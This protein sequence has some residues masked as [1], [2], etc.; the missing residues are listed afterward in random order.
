M[1]VT[2]RDFL[3]LT[4]SG[5]VVLGGLPVWRSARAAEPGAPLLVVVF[6]RGGADALSLVPPV[7]DP[8]YARRRGALAVEGALPFA[9]GFGLHP[10]LAP[11]APLVEDGRLAVV[12]CAGSH[13][14]SRSHFEAQ[15]RMELGS[16]DR[17]RWSEGGWLTRA[18]GEV[19]A[20]APFRQLGFGFASPAS[21][22]GAD[23]FSIGRPQTFRLAGA[24]RAAL[25][26]VEKRY[27]EGV[28]ALGASEDPVRRAGARGLEA[29]RTLRAAALD[30]RLRPRAGMADMDPDASGPLRAGGA[31][32]SRQVEGLVRLDAAGL[33]IEAAV[34]DLDGWDHHAAQ[35]QPFAR[36]AGGL[37]GGLAA[38]VRH[39]GGSASRRTLRVVVMTEFGRTVRPNGS[40]G[41]DHGHG[42]LMLVAAPD[43]KAG[44]HGDWRGL[45]D[46]A[47]FEGRDL[48]VTSDYRGVLREV[49]RA[50][51][52]G[53]PPEHTFP[54]LAGPSPDLFR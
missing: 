47:L 32:F 50:H 24:G 26:A 22:H 37:A 18:L 5:A 53:A 40:G 2:R 44:L 17:P 11:L 54:G 33:E 10:A 31:L 8:L 9:A 48:P 42:S 46:A 25:E 19:E 23:A 38:L 4:A 12:H 51:L 39:F 21:L 7:G 35:A 49:L 14:A 45:S 43:V 52:G 1:A 3:R 36:V 29:A 28:S 34:L 41:T 16:G 15:D 13:D 27:A 20:Q 30:G 6:L